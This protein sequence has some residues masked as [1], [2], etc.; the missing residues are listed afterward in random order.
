MSTARTPRA[1][2]R[3]AARPAPSLPPP[4][5][6][7]HRTTWIVGGC[8]LGLVLAAAVVAG[9]QAGTRHDLL[10]LQTF[11]NGDG[12]FAVTVGQMTGGGLDREDGVLVLRC[13]H[14]KVGAVAT[15]T[16]EAWSLAFAADT[17]LRAG[18]GSILLLAGDDSDGVMFEVDVITSY[19]ALWIGGDVVAQEPIEPLV[20]GS[21]HRLVLTVTPTGDLQGEIDGRSV[22]QASV[23]RSLAMSRVV[24]GLTSGEPFEVSFDNAEAGV[25]RSDLTVPPYE[26]RG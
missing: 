25:T 21:T 8:V 11:E 10:P 3:D 12:E 23:D 18:A 13:D 16:R 24:L 7:R 20:A 22:V 26:E 17:R 15:L 4:P 19:A 1:A 9:I 14:G 2:P 5:R 6:P